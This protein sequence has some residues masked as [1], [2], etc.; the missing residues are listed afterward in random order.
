METLQLLGVALGLA[1]LAGINLYL[2]VFVTGL[3]IRFDWITLADRYSQLEILAHP[4]I[5]TVA[6]VL[7]FIEFFADKIPWVDSAWDS[8][9]TLLRPIGGT[10]LAIQVLGDSNPV[11]DVIV[12]ML[13][14]GLSLVAHTF[15]AG[16]RVVVN[17]SPEPFSNIAV[18]FAEDAGVLGGLWLLHIN[19]ILAMGIFLA[20]MGVFAWFAPKI[21]RAVWLK[22]WLSWKK[23]NLPAGTSHED[24]LPRRLPPDEDLLLLTMNP[25]RLPIAWAVRCVP[26]RGK[27]L[28][29]NSHGWL[30]AL[31][32]GGPEVY[33]LRH[34]RLATTSERIDLAG[35]RTAQES[36]FLS[37]NLALYP[38]DKRPR[39]VFLFDRPRAETVGH[40]V[41]DL[42]RRIQ[43]ETPESGSN[44][45][46]THEAVLP[47]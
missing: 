31:E 47:A 8:A 24:P 30:V 10:L 13:A 16:T 26:I 35:Y 20:V 11:F 6:G 21:F 37:E 32:D 34:A 33:F 40:L 44:A 22:L 5:I 39:Y 18:S 19:P 7:Y 45:M 28:P 41:R 38:E 46:R 4:A 42:C 27:R 14:G 15:K 17:S 29:A 43:G 36:K 25:G 1:T 23:L 3:A 12:A 9:H 2:T